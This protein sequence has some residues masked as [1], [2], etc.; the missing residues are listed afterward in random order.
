MIIL[1]YEKT[2]AGGGN[3]SIRPYKANLRSWGIP[4]VQFYIDNAINDIKALIW[5]RSS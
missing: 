1:D 4:T 5:K 2:N 3:A